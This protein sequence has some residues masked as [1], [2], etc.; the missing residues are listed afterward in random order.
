MAQWILYLQDYNYTTEHR[1]GNRMKHVDSLSRHPIAEVM[2]VTSELSARLCK[3][4]QQDEHI[5]AITKILSKGP[6]ENYKLKGGLV[7]KTVNGNDLLVVPKVMESEIIRNAHDVG[8]FANQKTLHAIQQHYFIPHLEHKVGQ[9]ISNCIKCIIY[10]KKLGKKEGFLN[11]IEKGDLPLN[12]LHV[13]HLGPM[14]ST[15]KHYKYIFAMVD[16]FSKFVWLYPTKSTGAEE[17][18]RRLNE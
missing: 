9:F 4:Q 7:F 16:G 12:T 15:S 18:I 14:D 2:I 8:H 3:A 10:N 6:Y 13:D 17:V 1:A 11:C 5:Q